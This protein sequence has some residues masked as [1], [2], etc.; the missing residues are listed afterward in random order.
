MNDLLRTYE[1]TKNFGEVRA[2]RAISLNVRSR[3]IFALLGPNGAGKTTLVRMITHLILPDSG[4]VEFNYDGQ[5][6]DRIHASDVGFL[7]EDR[8]L[9][10]EVPVLRTLIYHGVMRGMGHSSARR[11]A[12]GW[13]ERLGLATRATDP[14]GTL[15]KG[16]QQ[17][18]QFIA[19]ILHRPKLA[20]LDEPFSGLDPLNQEVFVELIRELRDG[21][22]TI[23]LSAHHMDLVERIADRVLLMHQGSPV[24]YGTLDELRRQAGSNGRISFQYQGECDLSDLRGH[25]AVAGIESHEPGR[26][27]LRL[28]A[29]HTL[30]D[31]LM[32][33]SAAMEVSSVQCGPVTLRDI[34]VQ[35]LASAQVANEPPQP[36]APLRSAVQSRA[37]EPEA[38]ESL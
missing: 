20:V 7:P 8:S 2:V 29:D 1:L 24:L 31:L 10:P 23:I 25:S 14:V 37:P 36:L 18:V 21:G 5:L 32:T 6:R 13:L 15:S 27:C 35:A 9:L 30:S 4:R 17:K 26:L 33:A 16:N 28:H 19:S 12:E 11:E 34:Y 3:E 38:A 22:M